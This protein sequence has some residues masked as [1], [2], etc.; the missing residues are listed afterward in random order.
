MV[1]IPPRVYRAYTTLGYTGHIH[2]PR[3]NLGVL[4][5]TLGI[6]WVYYTSP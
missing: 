2:H 6:T 1:Y 4:Y 5:L 3:D